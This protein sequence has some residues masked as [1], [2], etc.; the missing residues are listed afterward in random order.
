M[1]S[2]EQGQTLRSGDAPKRKIDF[3]KPQFGPEA[4]RIREEALRRIGIETPKEPERPRAEEPPGTPERPS[5]QQ[6][7]GEELKGITN[8][9]TDTARHL[10]NETTILKTGGKGLA[11]TS[12]EALSARVEGSR[13]S[14]TKYEDA[15][16]E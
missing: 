16:Q 1:P 2:F 5:W 13:S 7:I 12:A 15:L 11:A 8:Q 4:D 9:K 14:I 6:T 3:S 10:E